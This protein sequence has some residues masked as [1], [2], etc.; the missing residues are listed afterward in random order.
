MVLV[1]KGD[2][3]YTEFIDFITS[4]PSLEQMANFRLSDAAETRL[5]ALLE[6]NRHGTL[7]A[8]EQKEL[9]DYLQLEHLMRMMKYTALAKLAEQ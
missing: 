6:A 8:E 4:E 5:N 3:Y 1:Q 2:R 7:T 9:N